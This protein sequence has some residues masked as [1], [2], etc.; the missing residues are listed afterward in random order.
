MGS[1]PRPTSRGLG[2]LAAGS[3]LMTAAWVF[4]QQDL[5][6]PAL[7][8]V[9]LPLTALAVVVAARPRF[10]PTR[11]AAPPVVGAGEP[12]DVVLEVTA[13]RPVPGGAVVAEDD[14]GPGLGAAHR[15]RVAAARTG[16]L[17]R[18]TYTVRPRRR[19]RY[20]LDGFRYRFGDLLGFWVYTRRV[21]KPT[22][23]VVTPTVV[24]LPRTAAR[25]YGQTGE[26][27]IP[28]TSVSGPDDVMVREYQARDD[29]RR[30]HWPST[31][32]AGTLMV[33]REE[34]AW[35]PT[36]WVVV[37]SR[38]G[39]HAPGHGEHPTFEWLVSAAAS[40]GLR[41][42]QDGY[43]VT[44]AD[45]EGA[46]REVTPGRPSSI[47]EWLDPL[48]DIDLTGADDLHAATT[49]IARAASEHLIVALLGRLDHQTADLLAGTTGSRQQRVALVVAPDAD[50][51]AD[52]DSGRGVLADHGWSVVE[53]AGGD[54]ASS[55][56]AGLGLGSGARR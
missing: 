10:L 2:F 5:V 46:T 39:V 23:L 13:V 4:G 38:A 11:T 55:W 21:P 16:D 40:I 6:W 45:A 52:F 50:A 35:D 3:L 47:S 14:P 32:R 19:G 53:T 31:A 30:I 17:T 1:W 34:A 33:R 25:A 36:A 49:T 7:F 41:L 8:L 9:F 18:E 26:T 27:P 22:P 44:L 42:L 43:T 12:S 54:L 48:V 29:V 15:F 37:D 20:S 51:R 24:A 28:Q 56:A